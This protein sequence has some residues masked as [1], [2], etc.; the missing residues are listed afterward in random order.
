MILVTHD[1]GV[2]SAV[3]DR[4]DVMYASK[5]V[6]S[7]TT[8]HLMTCPSHPYTSD[9][10]SAMPDINAPRGELHAIPGVPPTLNRQ[11]EW[12]PY[13]QR[14]K[15]HTNECDEDMPDLVQIGE[16]GI[17]LCACVHPLLKIGSAEAR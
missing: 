1:L 14:C 2:V 3:T 10:L 8:E 12:C 17:A 6:E 11:F 4:V 13:G 7:G 15:F 16:N 9:L 5:I